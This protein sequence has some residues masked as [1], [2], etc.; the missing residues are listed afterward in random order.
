MFLLSI[1]IILIS[2][3]RKLFGYIDPGTGSALFSL[4]FAILGALFFVLKSLIIK[5]KT[6]S[7]IKSTNNTKVTSKARIIIYGEDK[8]Y[9][10]LF[11]P[12]IEE[13]IKLETPIIYYSMSEDDPIFNIKS[14]YLYSEFIGTGNRAYARLNF[15]EADICLMTTPNLDVFQLKRS[16][17]VKKYIHIT[18]SPGSIGVYKMYSLDFFDAVFLNG[19][20]QIPDI[21]ELEKLRKTKEK[22]LYVVGSTYLDELLKQLNNIKNKN[23]IVED[24]ILI[25][26]SWGPNGLLKKFGKELI[27][28]LLELKYNIIIRPHPQSFISEKE[29]ILELKEYYNNNNNI[30]W[31]NNPISSYS[32]LR[33][34]AMISDFS[35]V[36]FDYCFLCEKPVLIPKFEYNKEGFDAYFLKDDMWQLKILP[37]ISISFDSNNVTNINNILENVIKNDSLNKEIIKA[38]NEAYA[39]IGKSS[40]ILSKIL[41][42]MLSEI[43]D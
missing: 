20:H 36:I 8:R 42:K 34:K 29:M 23:N 38:K 33:S 5:L 3:D 7:F 39:H 4:I 14:E 6:F 2:L 31:D 43:G 37:K 17:F 32:F 15:I 21:R 25:G 40:E 41:L 18:H 9:C 22:E 1:F 24:S 28:S 26:P 13:L 16:K 35:G 27:N 10:N 30:E 19:N 12:I 11:I